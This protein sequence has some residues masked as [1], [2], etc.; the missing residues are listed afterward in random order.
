MA[1]ISDTLAAQPETDADRLV[2]A[3][4]VEIGEL[5]V[6]ELDADEDDPRLQWFGEKVGTALRTALAARGLEVRKVGEA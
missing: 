3:L 5:A 6:M 4:V 2:E 1:D